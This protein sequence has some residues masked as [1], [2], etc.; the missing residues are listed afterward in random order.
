[1]EIGKDLRAGFKLT[2]GLVGILLSLTL[3]LA[4]L[5][6]NLKLLQNSNPQ[7]ALASDAFLGS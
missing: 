1:M 7:A 6:A 2:I 5:I 4:L 3:V